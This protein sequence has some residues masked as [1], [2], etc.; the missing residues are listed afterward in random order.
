MGGHAGH[1]AMGPV[2]TINGRAYPDTER[3]QATLGAVE[4]WAI[5]NNTEMDHPFH[6]HGFRFQVV[7]EGAVGPAFRAWRDTINV[8]ANSTSILRVR[9]DDQPGTWM[10]HCHI[11]EHAERG[12]AGELMVR[13]P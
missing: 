13:A 7:T 8:R 2:F 10:F 1:G 3:L 5:V 4:D 6:L 11:L 9:F 12:M